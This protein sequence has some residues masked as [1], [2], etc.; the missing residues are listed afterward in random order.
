G[1]RRAQFARYE[2]DRRA[3][4]NALCRPTGAARSRGAVGQRQKRQGVSR[5]AGAQG[6][7]RHLQR[8]RGRTLPLE[9]LG[10]ERGRDPHLGGEGTANG[11]RPWFTKFSGTL[12]DRRWL[13]VVEDIYGWHYR[14]ERWLRNEASLA[15]VGMVY[16]QQTATFY[17][18]T[19]AQQKVEDHTS[20]FY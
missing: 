1:R 2:N 16:S 10:A 7:R 20:G 19:R 8:G 14:A 5:D 12:Y 3:F 15:R 17:G 13:K 4:R 11:L 9:G 18:G 6:H